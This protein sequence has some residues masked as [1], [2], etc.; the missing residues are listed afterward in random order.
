MLAIAPKRTARSGT[1]VTGFVD[2]STVLLWCSV[3]RGREVVEPC[4][5]VL[6]MGVCVAG[7]HVSGVP[8]SGTTVA[9]LSLRLLKKPILVDMSLMGLE[10]YVMAGQ[11]ARKMLT[12][13]RRIYEWGGNGDQTGVQRGYSTFYCDSTME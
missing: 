10:M 6:V 12:K 1:L 8:F 4:A 3:A 5:G 7:V 9:S 11:G 13:K 2:V